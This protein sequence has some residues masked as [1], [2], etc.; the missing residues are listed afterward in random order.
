M[1][2]R[3]MEVIIRPDGFYCM[4]YDSRE[5]YK[6]VTV[7]VNVDGGQTYDHR[8]IIPVDDFKSHFEYFMEEATLRIK[9]E[10]CKE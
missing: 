1:K 6:E 3:H 5:Q 9:E 7:I 10:L 2:I 4:N 8:C